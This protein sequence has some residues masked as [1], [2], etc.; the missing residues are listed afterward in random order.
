MVKVPDKVPRVAGA[1][2]QL[3]PGEADLAG[4]HEV[5]QGREHLVARGAQARGEAVTRGADFV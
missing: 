1:P 4:E 5:R 2:V 3:G